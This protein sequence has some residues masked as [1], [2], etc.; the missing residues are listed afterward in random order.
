MSSRVSCPA[1][2]NAASLAASSSHRGRGSGEGPGEDLA[3]VPGLPDRQVLD[4]AE[5]VGPGGGQGAA[6]VVF[7]EP[8][9]LPD[10]R[11]ADPA[12]MVVQVLFGEF[13]DH[14]ASACHAGPARCPARRTTRSS[15]S[16][17]AISSP[18][19]CAGSVWPC[20][21][22]FARAPLRVLVHPRS[23]P[24]AIKFNRQTDG[25]FVKIRPTVGLSAIGTLVAAYEGETDGLRNGT[26]RQASQSSARSG[27]PG[28]WGR[29]RASLRYVHHRA[30]PGHLADDPGAC[31]GSPWNR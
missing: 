25:R 20:S 18:P 17:C 26:P 27:R 30:L 1:A 4:Q 14:G 16:R 24:S 3:E 28:D 15:A 8:V 23:A 5:Q 21:A 10:Q 12:Q 7:A 6:D 2:Q 29:V 13:I 19:R 9:E 11:L 31:M 22:R